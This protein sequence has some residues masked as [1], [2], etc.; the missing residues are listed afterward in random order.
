MNFRYLIPVFVLFFFLA[1]GHQEIYY[2]KTKLKS[3]EVQSQSEVIY[4][5]YLIG[6][7]G[8]D[9]AYSKYA[10]NLL[11][12][13]LKKENPD[14]TSV[15]F[16]GDNIYP[17]G[18]HR[19]GHPLRKQDE[20]RIN[21]QIE[22][23]EGFGGQVRF[24]PGNHDWQ[25]GKED[26]LEFIK[27][28]EDYIQQRLGK[29]FDPSDGCS[30]PKEILLNDDLVLIIIDTQWWLHNYDKAKGAKDDCDLRTKDGFIAAFKEALKSNRDKHIL[31][32]GHHPMYSNGVHGGHFTWQDHLF[33]LS[34]KKKGLW[35]PL[36]VIGSIYPF[37]RSFFGNVQDI[38][39]PKYQ[40]LKSELVTAMNEYDNVVYVAGH[41]HNMQYL[42][43]NR[44]HHI[45][46]GS[47]SKKT[48]L[49][50][51]QQID[52]GAKRRGYAV[53]EYYND[54]NVRLKFWDAEKKGG[55]KIFNQILYTKEINKFNDV[56]LTKP[57][58]EGQ[59]KTVVPD[60]NF[61]ASKF[62]RL[63]FG[64]L[65][66]ALWTL[67]IEVPVLDI[68]NDYGGLFPIGKGGGMQT[69]SLK[70]KG[71]DGHI[72]KAR[73]IKK[74]ADFLVG[75]DLQGTMAQDAVYDGIA[76]SHPY[77]SVAV[78]KIA[79]AAQI[80]YTQPRLVYIP[81]DSI[82]GDFKDEF[83]GMF[84][85]IEIHPDDDMSDYVNFGRS[86][87]VMNYNK[88]IDKLEKEAKNQIDVPFTVRS[89]LLD[90]LLGDWDRHDDQ[91]R[92]AKFK[93][94]EQNIF[95]P[96]PRD[97]DQ[98]FFQFDG[99]IMKIAN[100]KWLL[101]KFQPFKEEIRD[102]AGLNFN[103]RYFDRYFLNQAN[104]E[105]WI[106]EAKNLKEWITDEILNQALKD[107]PKQA[108][109]YNGEE[110]V[111]V[112]KLRRDRI[113]Q[114]A[115]R[116]YKVLAKE[117]DVRG[118]LEKDYFE[119]IRYKNGDVEVN[120]Y[121][122]KEGKK[123]KEKRFYH[124]KFKFGETKEIRLYGL[125]D[126][127]EYQ[128][129][130]ESQ[131]T[132]LVRIIASENKD[133]IEDKS[134][135]KNWRKST[136]VYDE[137]GKSDIDL[138]QEAKLHLMS[139]KQALIYDRKA[140][141]YDVL[142][143]VPSIGV[144][145]DDGFFFGPGFRF[146]KHGFNKAPYKYAHDFNLNYALRAEGFNFRYDLDYRQI[147]N[148]LNFESSL[149]FNLPE[150][151]QY[152]GQGNESSPSNVQIGNSDVRIDYYNLSTQFKYAS[153]SSSSQL[154]I[155]TAF[156]IADLNETPAFQIDYTSDHN[157]QFFE[158]TLAYKYYNTDNSINPTKGIGFD[159]EA[160]NTRSIINDESNFYRLST[161]LLFYVP[162]SY[163]EKQTLIALRGGWRQNFGDYLFYQSNF[164]SGLDQFR[165]ITRNRF[166][167]ESIAYGNAEIRKS[168]TKVKNYVMPFD[169]GALLHFDVG[170]VWVDQDQS[171]LWHNSY[172]AGL[173]FNVLNFMTLVGTYSIS[174]VDEVF[175]FGTKFYF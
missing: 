3:Q 113:D 75:R 164:L 146:V 85:L 5:T 10:L 58:Y 153:A 22:A 63:F 124:R 70:L 160:S 54:G 45:I 53:L 130:G 137:E 88:A 17:E 133:K 62:K 11:K 143:P 170:R 23:V 151:F 126:K 81:K 48:D 27:R 82:L 105:V 100:R 73:G 57:S 1:C 102:I 29:V 13:Q 21:I 163:F 83:G 59:M 159:L 108:Y 168:F 78:P 134:E 129:E 112:L 125:D 95:R 47:G 136:I 52:F 118:T 69:I 175:N 141:K 24:I 87:E 128:I 15:V 43:E 119:V 152:Y 157:Q 71:A 31:V 80:Y 66:R 131:K 42:K 173:Y 145:P 122:R 147:I 32:V 44:L 96:I 60:T 20:S 77:A 97:R 111:E 149:E 158:T 166:S 14:Q 40:E 90:M 89:R 171:N 79:E 150:V 86:K 155:K 154:G 6:D 8:G 39:H 35:I 167:G 4:K 132:I 25:K 98:V 172:G 72:Y 2:R 148:N 93:E 106:Q 161:E 9:T 84:A 46:S 115:K 28:Q 91:W 76:G 33:P 51:N 135:V 114:F 109:E 123:V 156:Q 165:G 37:G 103:A 99:L 34:R 19:E 117:V 16:L 121:P 107:L 110:L 104:E 50:F 61:R 56:K 174:D 138:G 162:V 26:G 68:H 94:D 92:W 127:D 64:N 144:N 38:S 55:E 101:R 41:E 65:N 36:P 7:A 120:I 49:R 169:L 67:P 18:L 116:Y 140:F 30:G 139:E 142:I 12:Q 74:N